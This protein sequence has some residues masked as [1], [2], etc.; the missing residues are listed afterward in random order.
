MSA[1]QFVLA[2]VEF[3]AVFAK[4]RNLSSGTR[5]KLIVVGALGVVTLW[6]A[7]WALFVRKSPRRPHRHHHG[8]HASE[9]AS[10]DAAPAPAGDAASPERK[11]LKWRRPR[12]DH[13][14][15]NPTL[16]ETGGLPPVREGDP[17]DIQP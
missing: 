15:R 2:S 5:E 8:H 12:R 11:R 4:W 1:M 17:P 16:A 9:P 6:V 10:H 14:P 3:D 7:V 13:R